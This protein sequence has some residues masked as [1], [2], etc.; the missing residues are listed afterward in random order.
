MVSEVRALTF[1]IFG[2]TVDWR[3][4]VAAEARRIGALHGVDAHWERL[5]DAWRAL[6]IP[7]MGRVRLGELPW[8]NFDR[9]HR[10][11]LDEVLSEVGADGFDEDA[12]EE[13]T[14][15][16]ERLPAWPDAVAGLARLGKRFIV[17]TLSNG[18]R[19]QQ[20]ALVRFASLP[21]QRQ[22]SAE[23]VRHYK[24]DPEVYLGAASALGLAPYE[25][26]M[27]AAHK[28]DLRA[29]QAAG[30][31]AA[32]VERP[33]EKGPGGGADRLPDPDS[34]V[35]ATDFIDLATQLGA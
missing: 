30:L 11:S 9:L 7:Y 28:G 5:A 32:F 12:R 24:P 1:D 4:G 13:L 34:D 10:L 27:V 14:R 21:F 18:N 20:A 31:R 6:Y 29:A 35:Q 17:S 26:M 15:A 22:L 23:D 2:T 16:W 3:T 8:T 19:S 25:L 33:L